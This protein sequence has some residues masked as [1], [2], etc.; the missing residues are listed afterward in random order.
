MGYRKKIDP[1]LDGFQEL[2]DSTQNPNIDRLIAGIQK[3]K[4]KKEE[5]LKLTG[6]LRNSH[7]LLDTELLRLG[8]FSENYNSA[9]APKKGYN[10]T[11]TEQLQNRTKSQFK[12]W[13][14]LLR[15]T[16]PRYKKGPKDNENPQSI[17]RAS[18]LTYRPYEPDIWGPASYGTLVTDLHEQLEIIVSHLDEGEQMCKD[19]IAKEEE[20]NNDPEWKESLYDEQFKSVVERNRDTIE[21]R[22]HS[23]QTDMS[24]P[25]LKD[26]LKHPSEQHYKWS[27][28]HKR[29]DTQFN[30][31]VIDLST[32][33][34][35]ENEITPKENELWGDDFPK[36]KEVR[37]AIE[38]ADELLDVKPCGK[39]DKFS[40][41]EMIKWCNVVPSKKKHEDAERVLYDYIKE[42][43]K[44]KHSWQGWPNIFE[45]NKQVKQ[46]PKECMDYATSF[47][48]KLNRLKV[49][50]S[51]NG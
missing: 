21:K 3:K 33:R 35:L 1:T 34:L 31:F 7:T 10:L 39:F 5:I 20:I 28:F 14:D 40:T 26:M 12:R 24:N 29:H 25:L 13:L 48:R 22:Y 47:E 51:E 27:D 6:E 41:L 30:D 43:Y 37:F 23:G 15:I 44:G 32:L 17:F 19:T 45:L 36:I 2:W 8:E 42:T 46:S 4:A 50:L 9:W 18:Y 49:E 38:H 16:T 11:T